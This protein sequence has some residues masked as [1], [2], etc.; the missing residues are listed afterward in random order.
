MRVL[1]TG[2]TGYIGSR[3]VPRLLYTDYTVRA[4]SRDRSK[5]ASRPWADHPRVELREGNALNSEDM[6]GITRDCD[7]VFY[8]IH[9]MGDHDDFESADRTAAHNMVSAATRNNVKRLIYLGGLGNEGDGLSPHLQSRAEVAQIFR[10]SDVTET[11]LRAAII[12][13]SG[14][15]SFEILRYLVERLPI[16]TTP[17]W[18]H[19]KNQPI[20][21]RN[22]LNY[23]VGCLD[24]DE[25][26][27]ETYDIGGP[28][29]LTYGELMQTYARA[30]G[31]G[32]RWIIPLPFLT[33]T[34]SSYW[35]HLVTPV[36][37]SI[38]YPLIEG[39]KSPVVCE[40]SRIR[41]IIDQD[42]LTPEV[43]IEKALERVR[44]DEIE[45]HWSDAGSIPE[46]EWSDPQDPDWAGGD[47][48]TDHRRVTIDGNPESVWEAIVGI[49]GDTGWYHA[50]WLWRLRGWLDRMVGGVGLRRGRRDADELQVGDALDFW[51]VER[52]D[53]PYHLKLVAEMKLPGEATLDFKISTNDSDDTVQL[54]QIARFRPSGVMG[55]LYWY[56]VLPLHAFVFSGMLES[57]AEQSGQ[58]QS[59]PERLIRTNNDAA[60]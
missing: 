43:A 4:V 49:G 53:P 30:A 57:I 36:P 40:D 39:M 14:S 59:G 17:K 3:L 45:S 60:D 12:I 42:L 58:L 23:L 47:I 6:D 18:V 52:L 27:G 28:K 44:Q 11:I 20:A 32:R 38:A 31:L 41:D 34:L 10:E 55:L 29:V 5:L 13:G 2:A 9:S 50:N 33:P 37:S 56:I 1:V 8:L 35:V 51:R 46:A 22:V 48:Y 26:A 19:T 15:A 25:T 16:M 54:D 7:A 21:I 24:E